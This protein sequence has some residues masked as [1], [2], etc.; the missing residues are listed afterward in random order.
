MNFI[1]PSCMS[2]PYPYIIIIMRYQI[3]YLGFKSNPKND[4]GSLTARGSWQIRSKDDGDESC[5]PGNVFWRNT[6]TAMPFL[7]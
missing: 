1:L 3:S 4:I 7:N 2:Y 6:P 5:V